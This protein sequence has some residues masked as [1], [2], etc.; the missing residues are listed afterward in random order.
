MKNSKLGKFQVW[1]ENSDEF[2]E[3]KKEIFG[4]NS[5]YLELETETPRIVDAGA[6]I[7]LATL[8][9]K[10]IFP[11]S[12]IT[13]YE[14][15]R[16]NLVL[17]EK[18]VRENQLEGVEICEVAVAPKTGRLKIHEPSEGTAWKSGAGIIPNGWRGVQN[19]HEIE[20]SAVGIQEILHEPIDIFKMDIEGMEYEV[21]QSAR[22]LIRHVKK[23]IIEAH[24]RKGYRVEA[25]VKTLLQNGYNVEQYKDRSS[26]GVGLSRIVAVLK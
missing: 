26:L 23:W 20:V 11:N 18:N 22:P 2:Y 25:M 4:E 9:F 15:V 19:T 16:A 3:L 8:Y 10:T 1:Y 13:A 17:L 7:G 24:P 6:H 14:P 21:L 5:Y 12:S